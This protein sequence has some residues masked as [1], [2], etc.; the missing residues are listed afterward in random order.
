[1]QLRNK[2]DIA[3]VD[4]IVVV[5]IIIVVDIASFNI[6]TQ[7][8]DSHLLPYFPLTSELT[9]NISFS[10]LRNWSKQEKGSS[11]FSYFLLLLDKT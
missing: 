8:R 10:S 7:T 11:S 4:I 5:D 6:I 9:F 1:L 3:V 2:V